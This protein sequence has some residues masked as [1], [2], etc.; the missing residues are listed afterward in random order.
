MPRLW[1]IEGEATFALPLLVSRESQHDRRG[2][3][4]HIAAIQE[5]EQVQDLQISNGTSCKSSSQ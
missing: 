5:T 2:R 1:L 4:S 3:N